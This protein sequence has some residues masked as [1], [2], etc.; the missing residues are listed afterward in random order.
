MQRAYAQSVQ[1]TKRE[2]NEQAFA[3]LVDRLARQSVAKH[4]DAFTD[5]PWDDQEYAI[6]DDDPR[7]SLNPMEPLGA[8]SWYRSLPVEVRARIGL[9]HYA[10]LMKIGI[11]F[12]NVLQ[13]GLLEFALTLPPRAPEFRYLHHEVIEESQH[14]LMFHE[15]IRRTGLPVQGMPKPLLL[16]SRF[17][18]R[19]ARR[20]PE[21][22]FFFV[23]GGEEPIDYVQR[24]LLREADAVHPLLRR[25]MQIH[26]TEEARHVCFARAFLRLHVPQ[27][28]YHRR[29]LLSLRVPLLLGQMAQLM[30]QPSRQLA[31]TYGIPRQVLREA[32]WDNPVHRAR[33][34]A[35]VKKV[36]DLCA[37]LGLLNPSSS[38]LWAK[39][40]IGGAVV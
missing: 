21:L 24:A 7:W 32:Y 35:S 15:F 30:L 12:E 27:L 13:R 17:V 8:T 9:H 5:V 16:A 25:I 19:L 26:V 38:W 4:Y 20:F 22:F 6:R 28:P 34:A 11:E 36:H 18:V 39:V 1:A 33:L 23:L 31:L 10:S 40:G 37:E 14:S 29:V 2:S 3:V